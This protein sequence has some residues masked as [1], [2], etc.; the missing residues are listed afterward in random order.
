[1]HIRSKKL[2]NLIRIITPFVLIPLVAILGTVIFDAKK[3][4]FISLFV[5]VLSLLVFATGFERKSTG[6]RRLVISA[7]MI[8]LSVVGRMIPVFK[9]VT[10]MTIISA[11]YLGPEAGFLVGSMSAL[12]SNFF[13][14]QGPWTPFQM[15]GWGLIGFIAGLLSKQLKKSR[16]LLLIYGLVSGITY[17]FVM[18]IWTVLWHQGGFDLDLYIASIVTALPHTILYAVSNCAFL[19]LL[20]PAFGRKLERIKIKY[21]V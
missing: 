11:V 15:L 1:M 3:H 17:S 16:I 21:G 8:A 13:F 4:I 12:L 9:P 2:R 6:S 20:A 5:A 10:A 18:D 7:V 19:W 14:G